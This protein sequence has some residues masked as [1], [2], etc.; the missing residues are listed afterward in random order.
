MLE[1]MP[2][3]MLGAYTGLGFGII[4]IVRVFILKKIVDNSPAIEQAKRQFF[5]EY[6]L[7]LLTGIVVVFINYYLFSVPIVNGIVFFI[8]FVSF[9]FFIAIDMSL[10]KERKVIEYAMENSDTIM[11]S[12]HFYPLTRKFFI[13]ALV[14]NLLVMIIIMLI[15]GRDLSWLAGMEYSQLN[16]MMGMVTRTIFK[17]ISFVIIILLILVINIL[18]SY[19]KN[20][21]LLFQTETSVLESVTN[22]DLSKLV[23][24]ATSDEFG[25]IASNTNKMIHGL[26]DRIRILSRLNV[27]KEV[28]ENLLPNQAPSFSN[29]DISGTSLYCEEVGGDYFDFFTFSENRFGIALTDSSGHG[30]GAGLHMTTIRAFFRYGVEDYKGP[31]EL[32]QS[33][34]QHITRD[35]YETGRF[36]TVFFVEVDVENYLIKWIRAGHEPALLYTPSSGR[37]QKLLG[38]GMALGVDA[39]A[40][41][42]EYEIKGW[43]S[44]TILVIFSDGLKESRNTQGE[45]YGEKR[46]SKV[47]KQFAAESAKTIEKNLIDGLT[48]FSKNLPIEDDITIVTVKFL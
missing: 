6:S 21:K 36:T 47:I 25:V 40:Q 8:G 29:M 43:E 33:V 16:I 12:K 20:L 7:V 10:E 4:S 11:I 39:E 28:Q 24:V 31:T 35:S 38:S 32:I 26:R 46:I 18:Y 1:S 48:D 34:N 44:G 22:G 37:V 30:V 5:S 42:H 23:P 3:G 2:S 41:I 15:I 17:E 14:T 13:V 9:G 19:S 27:A 45:M